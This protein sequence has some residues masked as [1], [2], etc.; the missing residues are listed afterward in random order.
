MQ[1]WLGKRLPPSDTPLTTDNKSVFIKDSTR[2]KL[3][4]Q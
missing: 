2:T 3:R 4:D 1:L